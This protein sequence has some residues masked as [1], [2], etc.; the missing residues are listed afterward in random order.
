MHAAAVRAISIYSAGPACSFP[1]SDTARSDDISPPQRPM[2]KEWAARH[3]EM[4]ALN[5]SRNCDGVKGMQDTLSSVR[6]PFEVSTSFGAIRPP[7][8]ALQR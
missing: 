7:H 4:D 3:Q 1:C 8:S 5:M 2:R 6:I